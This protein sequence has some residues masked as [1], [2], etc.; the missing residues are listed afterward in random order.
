MTPPPDLPPKAGDPVN[1]PCGPTSGGGGTPPS[2]GG[3]VFLRREWLSLLV[4][5]IAIGLLMTQLWSAPSGV[6]PWRADQ[7]RTAHQIQRQ[8]TRW[9]PEALQAKLMEHPRLLWRL[10]ILFWTGSA[11]FLAGC[12][13]LAGGIRRRWK[14]QPLLGHTGPRPQGVPVVPWGVWDVTKVF[15]WIVCAAHGIHLLFGFVARMLNLKGIDRYL[16]AT[17]STM[18]LD[19]FA[20]ILVL[21]LVLRRYR[22]SLRALGF[23]R[24]RLGAQVLAGVRSY[25]G[26]LPVFVAVVLGGVAVVGGLGWEPRPQTV[27]VMLLRESRQ[28]LLLVLMGLVA[29]LGPIAEEIVFRGVAYAG[30]RRRWGR[31]E[32]R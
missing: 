9:T 30:F 14:H 7:Q 20:V 27:I 15:A 28:P 23:S 10:A 31:S 12:L 19:G 24:E 22:V 3:R 29:V 18:A 5:T 1:R 2:G 17:V 11:A 8:A 32:E 21:A 6:D 13:I 4:V 26:W 25:L 16:A